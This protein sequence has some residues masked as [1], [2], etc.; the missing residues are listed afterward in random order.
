MGGGAERH[1]GLVAKHLA[2]D[3]DCEIITTTA[4][5]Y[6][7][8]ADHYPAGL[9]TSGEVPVR[10]FAVD[11]PRDYAAFD[12][13]S[14]GVLDHPHTDEDES[15]W[16]EAQGPVCSRLADHLERN[17]SQYDLFVFFT[18]LYWTTVRG[19]PRVADK[20]WLAPTAHDEKPIYLSVFNDVFRA[21]RAILYNTDAEMEFCRRRFAARAPVEVVVGCGVEPPSA[22]DTA[23]W[24]QRLQERG[25]EPPYVLYLGR[26]DPAK[27]CDRLVASYRR[28][29]DEDEGWPPLVLV[30]PLT[31][32][33]A[34]HPRIVT[35]GL[36][37]E[38]TKSAAL[39]EAMVLVQPSP[40]ESL[41]LVLLE[42]WL[43]E[44]PVLVNGRC[45]VL[46]RQV[47]AAGGGLYYESDGE[48]REALIRL[49]S[50]PRDGAAFGRAGRAFV[51]TRY[52]WPRIREAYLAHYERLVAR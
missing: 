43:A 24:R 5:D 25:V 32:Q 45:E 47:V 10:R 28:L 4:D 23:G 30:G 29:L 50:R 3:W 37:D 2:G 20:A 46:R 48:L 21:P 16:I 42:A 11:R 1:C 12:R 52:T 7:T 17:T 33:V 39:A 27:G 40:F 41:S 26:V 31:M 49:L 18:Y 13:I 34:P 6:R 8:W 19:L 9:D 35:M 15:A 38:A 36:V 22:P 14:P 44:R 51:E